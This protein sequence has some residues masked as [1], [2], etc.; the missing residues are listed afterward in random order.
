VL[1]S[2]TYDQA[3]P[4]YNYNA[5]HLTASANSARTQ[6]FDYSTNGAVQHM[7]ETDAAGSQDT[8]TVGSYFGECVLYKSYYPSLL[9]VGTD[10]NRWTYDA[11]GR[12]KSIPGMVAL[13]TY[14]AD[15]QTKTIT[16]ANGV[17]TTFTYDPNRRWLQRILTKN[18]SGVPLIDNSYSRAASGRIDAINGL[19]VGDTWQYA[20]DDLA[21]RQAQEPDPG[22]CAGR[23]NNLGN[24]RLRRGRQHAL[25]VQSRRPPVHL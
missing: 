12:L 7:A 22:L 1:T 3:R 25:A 24:L 13:Q 14:E 20:Y 6:T 17:T 18:A 2:N 19:A 23:F 15:G 5:G 9:N 21:L 8:W 11:L 16:Y 10:A 4:Y